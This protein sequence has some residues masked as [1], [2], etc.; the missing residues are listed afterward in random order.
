MGIWTFNGMN[1]GSYTQRALEHEG[2]HVPSQCFV[3]MR[4]NSRKVPKEA[5]REKN[6]MLAVSHQHK[7]AR[8][9]ADG[10]TYC[11]TSVASLRTAQNRRTTGLFTWAIL[12]PLNFFHLIVLF[13]PLRGQH[14]STFSHYTLS[15]PKKKFFCSFLLLLKRLKKKKSPT[16]KNDTPFVVVI[17]V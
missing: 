17:C 15:A 6:T 13:C 2:E 5:R 3:V 10:N 14:F 4:P 8:R 16:D 11:A 12:H 1:N 7:S 9:R